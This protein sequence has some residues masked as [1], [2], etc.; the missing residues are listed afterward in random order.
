MSSARLIRAD[1]SIQV[2]SCF[3]VGEGGSSKKFTPVLALAMTIALEAAGAAPRESNSMCF[4]I[5][6]GP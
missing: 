2:L 3:C 6:N 1:A 4:Y 5:Y